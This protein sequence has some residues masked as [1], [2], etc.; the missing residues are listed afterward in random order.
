MH[1]N[2]LVELTGDVTFSSNDIARTGKFAV[3]SPQS[4]CDIG[5]TTCQVNSALSVESTSA[6]KLNQI[7]YVYSTTF[8]ARE[9]TYM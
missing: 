9:T 7:V 4:C 6:C 3:E 2:R 1:K 5:V 8:L